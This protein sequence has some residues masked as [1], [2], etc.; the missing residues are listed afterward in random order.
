MAQGL[1]FMG[2]RYSSLGY[3]CFYT[4]T[5]VGLWYLAMRVEG[6]ANL[7]WQAVAVRFAQL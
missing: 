3:D 6:G 7:G 4:A 2:C 1:R 5:D